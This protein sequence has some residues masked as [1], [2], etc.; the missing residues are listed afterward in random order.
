M[1][2]KTTFQIIAIIVVIAACISGTIASCQHFS[3]R[4]TELML[5]NGYRWV[6]ATPARMGHWEEKPQ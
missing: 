4:E 2:M 1:S 5:Q 6:P 3:N